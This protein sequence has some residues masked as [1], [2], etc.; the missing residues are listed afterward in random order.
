MQLR[1]ARRAG[2]PSLQK[3]IASQLGKVKEITHQMLKMASAKQD[4]ID[5]QSVSGFDCCMGEIM[6]LKELK[7]WL[8]A[9]E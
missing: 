5:R 7:T 3:G 2:A 4:L 6:H 1:G 9:V 8:L